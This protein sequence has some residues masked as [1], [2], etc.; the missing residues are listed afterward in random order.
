VTDMDS[1][2]SDAAVVRSSLELARNLNLEVVGDVNDASGFELAAGMHHRFPGRVAEW[3]E[4]E[5]FCRRS[6][7]AHAE[8]SRVENAGGVEH[9]RVPGRND[10]FEVAELFVRDL[11]RGAVD[12]HE[13]AVSATSSR[14]LGD[15]V[16]GEIEVV[17]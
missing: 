16:G 11:A 15:A 12:D 13:P 10:L 5:D 6:I 1:D 14:L 8:E 2:A 3:S 17:V 9:D 4:Q 7:L